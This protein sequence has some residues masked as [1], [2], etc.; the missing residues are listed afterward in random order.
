MQDQIRAL[1]GNIFS[2]HSLSEQIS[3]LR[4]VRATIRERLQATESSLTDARQEIV[5]LRL[6]DQKQSRQIVALET[7]I[8][9]AQ[10]QSAEAPQALLRIQDLDSR[11]KDLQSEIVALRK[12]A[13]DL[14]SQLQQSL[15]E[16]RNVTE[17]LA[18][19]QEM[20]ESTSEEVARLREEKSTSEKEATF[21]REQLRK[22]LSKA[23]QM[24]LAHLQSEHLNVVQ[25]LKFEK[26]PAEEKLKKVNIQLNILKTDKEKSDKESIQLQASLKAAQSDKDAVIGTRKALQLHLKEMEARMLEK[27]NEYRDLQAMLNEARKQVIAKDLEIIAL[28]ASLAKRTSSSRTMEQ[29]D[30]TRGARSIDN[31]KALHQD[32]QHASVDP[33]PA[34]RPTTSKSSRHFTNRRPVVEDSQPTGQPRFV[35]L[36]DIMLDDPFAEYAQEGPHTIADE[37]IAHLFPTTPG[38]GSSVEALDYTRKSVFQT[39][40]V[41]EMQRRHHQSV[42]EA[43]PYTRTRTTKDPDTQSQADTLSRSEHIGVVPRSSAA[44]SSNNI[45]STRRDLKNSS[46]NRKASITRESTQPQNSVKNPGQA[47]RNTAAAGFNDKNSSSKLQKAEPTQQAQALGRVVEDSQSPLLN[48][49]NRKMTNRKSSAPRGKTPSLRPSRY[50]ERIYSG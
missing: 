37:D 6:R 2:E 46:S 8:G 17:R 36:D 1:S 14:S 43:T 27:N 16:T 49:R 24:Q 38:G 47:K 23:A 30:I 34:V 4:E 48:G 35:S 10:S 9:K 12:K 26:F 29:D 25:Q 50:A 20:V 3:D 31:G 5:A 22:E 33:N 45:N 28:R 39:T 7:N 13:T 41:S 44:T 15:L 19:A 18:T 42:R 11:N 21:E 32:S 40:T